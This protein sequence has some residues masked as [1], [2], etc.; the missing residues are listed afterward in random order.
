M[1]E[2]EHITKHFG[3]TIAVNDISFRVEVGDIMGFLGPNGA[4]KTT[5]MRI[6][7]GFFPPTS[8]KARVAGFDV[9]ADSRKVRERIGYLPE[10]TPLYLEMTVNEHL[11]FA[12]EVK[13]RARKLRRSE[14]DAVCEKC[15]LSKVRDRLVGNLSSGY[16]QR[17][18]L[19]QALIGDPPVLVP[20]QV[21]AVRELIKSLA[22][23]RTIILSTHILSEVNLICNKVV[24]INQGRIAR[25]GNI[26]SLSGGSAGQLRVSARSGA[27]QETP[28]DGVEQAERILR[29]LGDISSV[30]RLLTA[31]EATPANAF[32]FFLTPRKRP[33]L[34]PGDIEVKVSRALQE[35]GFDLVELSSSAPTLEELFIEATSA[36][37]EAKVE[38]EGQADAS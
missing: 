19:A 27:A 11:N 23:E 26:A 8:G 32:T 4:G 34:K 38:K 13:G 18:G 25:Q 6:L 36:P 35:A 10:R 22:E 2:V 5:T 7:T 37:I 24:I 16:R 12:H 20:V 28:N 9:V 21:V 15:G 17:V 3:K 33:H 14:V 1:I 29:G 31:P 30:K